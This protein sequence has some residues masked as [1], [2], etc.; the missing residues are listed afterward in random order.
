MPHGSALRVS[1][2][3]LLACALLIGVMCTAVCYGEMVLSWRDVWATLWQRCGYPMNVNPVYAGIIWEYRL[4]RTLMA[5]CAGAA[6][7]VSGVL[8]Q[9]VLRNVLA[10]PYVLGM[11]AGA[12]SGAVAILVLGCGDASFGLTF[13]AFSGAICSFVL[14][15]VLAS[16]GGFQ[17]QRT[18]LAGIAT[19]QTF[20]ALTAYVVT[21]TASAEQV[22]GIT[23]WLL[24]D[25]SSVRM[26]DVP[27]VVVITFFCLIGS[28]ML[29]RRLDAFLLGENA[30]RALGIAVQQV[31]YGVLTLTALMTATVV[32]HVGAIG[33]VGMVVPHVACYWTGG[34]HRVLLPVAAW[35]D[36]LFLML[37]D[38]LSRS[39]ALSQA[40]PVGV[41]TALVGAP[42]FATLVHRM[43]RT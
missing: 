32:S 12:S 24:D 8:L 27:L 13:G 42:L 7:A 6:L 20:N 33:F 9:A 39:L 18:L 29:A 21:S 43:E 25:L 34:R 14:V 22:R 19:A 38:V 11:S 15:S 30:V 41:M 5:A 40:L 17:A 2:T 10:E 36:A 26:S 31:R 16:K 23:F 1:G 37:A 28:L 3:V 4:S 35:L